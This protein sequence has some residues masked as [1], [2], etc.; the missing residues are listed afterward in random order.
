MLEKAQLV[1]FNWSNNSGAIDVKMDGFVLKENCF[2]RSFAL[3]R[4]FTSK[5]NWAS[6]IV[7]IANMASK[8]IK[9]FIHSAKF[10]SPEAVLCFINLPYCLAW[11]Y[12]FLF[13]AGT[14]CCYLDMLDLHLLTFVNPLLLVEM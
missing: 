5:L 3:Y 14:P 6:Y 9:A 12:C 1:S 4:Y 8:K 11:K 2:L 10:L 13:W 7:S